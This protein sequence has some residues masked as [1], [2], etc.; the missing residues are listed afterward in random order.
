MVTNTEKIEFLE[1]KIKRISLD[2]FNFEIEL[3][4]AV[5]TSEPEERIE[6]IRLEVEK[7]QLILDVLNQE[8]Q[9]ATEGSV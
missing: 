4:I 6:P 8:L 1:R 3:K 2:K 7:Q 5:A 9:S